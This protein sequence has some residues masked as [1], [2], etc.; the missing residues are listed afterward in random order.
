MNSKINKK[1]RTG[2]SVWSLN[3]TAMQMAI[4]S[5]TQVI[6][7]LS[8]PKDESPTHNNKGIEKVDSQIH[9]VEDRLETLETQCKTMQG[10]LQ[11]A[12][13]EVKDVKT[14]ATSSLNENQ[15]ELSQTKILLTKIEQTTEK[16]QKTFTDLIRN[17]TGNVHSQNERLTSL[18]NKKAAPTEVQTSPRVLRSTGRTTNAKIAKT[19]ASFNDSQFTNEEADSES[20]SD[21][22]MKRNK[23]A[24]KKSKSLRDH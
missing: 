22:K 9:M 21:D 6:T 8:K 16:T 15:K 20:S 2:S 17:L 1:K 24:M 23:L 3:Q 18:E 12:L 19:S 13:H 11:Q 10:T 14:H 7:V 4:H 5:S